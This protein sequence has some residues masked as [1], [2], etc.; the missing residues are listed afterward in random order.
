[1][2][3]LKIRFPQIT[4]KEKIVDVTDEQHYKFVSKLSH[5]DEI[6]KFIWNNMSEEEQKWTEGGIKWVKSAIDVD[7]AG[8]DKVSCN[9]VCNECGFPDY[10]DSMSEDEMHSGLLQCSNCGGDEFHLVPK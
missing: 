5:I 7:Y 10:N 1:M 8:V 6:T 9:W 4:F 2:R 3:K